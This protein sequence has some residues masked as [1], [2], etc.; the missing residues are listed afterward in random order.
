MPLV[1]LY[2]KK[3][4]RQLYDGL[5]IN[6][7]EALETVIIE[8]L[9]SKLYHYI[10]QLKYRYQIILVMILFLKRSIKK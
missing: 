5:F 9:I 6:I 1:Q 8:I 2:H 3:T 10:I 4:I 7:K